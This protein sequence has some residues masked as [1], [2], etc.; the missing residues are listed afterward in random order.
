MLSS[1]GG[2]SLIELT[3]GGMLASI[4]LGALGTFLMGSFQA[5]AFTEGQSATLD[6]V[7]IVMQKMEKEIRGAESI[8]WARPPC[9]PTGGCIVVGA[10]TPT[11]AFR[12]VRYT[13]AG[14]ELRREVLDPVTQT[15]G[16]AVTMIERVGNSASQP[17]FA[18]D[19]QS[20]LLR[21]TIDLYIEPTPQ[22]NPNLNVQTTIRPRNFDQKATCPTP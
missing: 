1:D 10:Q 4:V 22:S 17:V 3:V 11:G 13:H 19:T 12:T 8:S 20:T 18:C 15:Y 21:V 9:P 16:T 5:G 6:D 7:R 2:F 14:T